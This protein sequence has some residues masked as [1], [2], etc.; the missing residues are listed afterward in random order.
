MALWDS[1]FLG[2]FTFIPSLG[3]KK[4]VIQYPNSLAKQVGPVLNSP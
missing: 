3:F 1:H 2:T 4:N